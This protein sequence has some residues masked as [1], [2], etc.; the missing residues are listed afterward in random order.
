MSVSANLYANVFDQAF[1][2]GVN[3]A[4]DSI[5]MALLTSAYTPSLSTHV[6]WSDVSANEVTGTGYTAG[7]VALASKTHTVTA[8]NSWGTAWGASTVY[9][10]GA[11]VRPS[12]G[13]GFLY[14]A[15]AGGTSGGT[16]PTFPTVV[17]AT[18]TDNT[19]TWTNIGESITQWSSA[20]ASWSGS[21][22]TAAYGIIY[23][24]QTGTATT[25]P[26]IALVNFGGSVSSTNSTFT[27]T[28]PSLGWFW[29]TPA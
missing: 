28:V 15:E 16:A 1:S 19:V 2:G 3:W 5:K 18:V 27:I 9:G 25:E 22:I 20:S 23:D 13:N 7:G 4:S 14:Y 26:L 12:T 11:V 24:A 10:Q 17:G 8:A 29:I 21:T 6:H